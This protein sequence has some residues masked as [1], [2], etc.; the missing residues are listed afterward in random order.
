MGRPSNYSLTIATKICADIANGLSMR[1]IAGKPGYPA[2]ERTIW[3][4]LN[5]HDGFRQEYANARVAQ[6]D[7]AADEVVRTGKRAIEGEID[8]QA[9]RVY[10]EALKWRAGKLNSKYA[11]RQVIEHD[12]SDKLLDRIEQAE[13]RMK[14]A[15]KAVN[16]LAAAKDITD[17]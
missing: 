2:K 3:S 8:P 10:S 4:W 7:W 6:Q 11:D 1:E 17:I 9:A 5:K 15:S 14:L 12:M 13:S 16:A